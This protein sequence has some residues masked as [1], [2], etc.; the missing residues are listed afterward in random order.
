MDSDFEPDHGP[1]Y[2]AEFPGERQA[3]AINAQ[4]TLRNRLKEPQFS[5]LLQR[6]H[7]ANINIDAPGS[8]LSRETL[9]KMLENDPDGLVLLGQALQTGSVKTDF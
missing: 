3:A 5:K 1:Q 4:N 8:F 6:L 2:Q 9:E 7:A